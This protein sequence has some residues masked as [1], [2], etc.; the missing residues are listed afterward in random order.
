MLT[1]SLQV[2][3]GRWQFCPATHGHWYGMSTRL[4]AKMS[5][6]MCCLVQGGSFSAPWVFDTCNV[7]CDYGVRGT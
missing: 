7:I 2:C 4:R 3:K 5:W 6:D 1:K